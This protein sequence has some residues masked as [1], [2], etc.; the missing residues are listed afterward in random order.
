MDCAG[1]LDPAQNIFG[2][3][4][5]FKSV[6][7]K[8]QGKKPIL[9]KKSYRNTAE[10]LDLA[11]TFSKIR[12]DSGP[13]EEDA[14][15]E[16]WL[17]PVDVDRHGDS[18]K[19]IAG[20]RPEDQIK[21][22]IKEIDRLI[23]QGTCSWADIGVIYAT[24]SYA[25]FANNFVQGFS[26]RFG[27]DKVYWVCKS[28]ANKLGLDL[29]SQSVKLSTI[30]SAKGIEFPVVFLVGLEVLP[31]SDRDERSARNLAYVGITRAQG[32]LYI[33]GNARIGFFGEIVQLGN[34]KGKAAKAS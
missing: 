13:E 3:T 34:N 21:F 8:V 7:I 9:L 26:G 24:Q 6:G 19:I 16:S 17:F 15:L 25:N 5:T 27:A 22:I 2:R 20:K 31:G 29:S 18:P 1:S 32:A 4:I 12:A 28:R 14:T 11:R 10:I 30:D 33:L 23:S